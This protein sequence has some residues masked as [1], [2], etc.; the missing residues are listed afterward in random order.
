MTSPD[1]YASFRAALEHE[2]RIEKVLHE[3]S[4]GVA[5]F[6]RDL[7]LDRRV[8]VRAL[9]PAWAGESRASEF[10][11]EAR[12]L[13]SLSHPSIPAIHHA[14]IIG[15]FQFI[16]LERA[17]GPTLERRLLDGAL[18]VN[19]VL[20][21]GVQILGALETAHAAGILHSAVVPSNVIVSEGRYVLDG[22]GRA[23]AGG[24]EGTLADLTA[25]GRL[26]DDASGGALLPP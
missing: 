17:E 1:R 24:H 6:A 3:S 11:R 15:N 25:V 12:V 4:D 26:L 8:L 20:R 14:G 16:V 19:E 7:T 22:F 23:T 21:L 10:A 9:D 5:Y 2:F 13:A 18:P